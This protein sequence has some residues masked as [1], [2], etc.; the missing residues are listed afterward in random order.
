[1][2]YRELRANMQMIG[3]HN[4]FYL[5]IIAKKTLIFDLRF[6]YKSEIVI[7]IKSYV[8][9]SFVLFYFVFFLFAYRKSLFRQI[10]IVIYINIFILM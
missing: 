7:I 5:N 8:Y 6:G 10:H 4:L 1:M 2:T 3:S 9:F